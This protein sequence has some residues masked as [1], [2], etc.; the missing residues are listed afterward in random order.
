MDVLPD[1]LVPGLDVVFCGTAAGHKSARLRAY[2]A[3]PGNLFWSTLHEI[4]L[5]PVRL[6]PEQ[7]PRVLEYGIG[8]T[9]LAKETSGPDHDLLPSDFSADGLRGKLRQFQPRILAFTSKNAAEAFFGH[10]VEFGVVDEPI[11]GVMP[12]VLNSP[13]QRAK[14]HWCNGRYWRDLASLVDAIRADV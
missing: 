12:F 2:Y 6:S 3:G 10:E 11:E 14:K 7:Y 5:A 4:G 8:L 9:D 1:V 13:S